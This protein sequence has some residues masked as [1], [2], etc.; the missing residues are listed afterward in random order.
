MGYK[1]SVY[2]RLSQH[3]DGAQTATARQEADCRALA[4]RLS[5]DVVAVYEDVDVSAYDRRKKRP[6]YEALLAAMARGEV[7]AVLVYDQ[8]RLVRHPAELERFIDAADRAGAR[9][10]AVTGS[11]DLST[12]VGRFI[13]RSL[14]NVA[15]MES[16]AKSR[17]LQRKHLELAQHGKVSGGGRRPFGYE[18][19]R[20]TLRPEEADLVRDAARR[21][22]AGDSVRSVVRDWRA[23]GVSTVTGA[24]WSTTTVKRLL[25][26][27][28]ISGQREHKGEL[29]AQATWPA[30]VTPE[31][32]DRLRALL[33]DPARS[34]ARGVEAYRYLLT[35]LV[36]C[37]RCEVKMSARP[38]AR[39]RR[40]YVCT[41]DRGGCDRCGIDAAGLEVLVTEAVL[42]AIDSPALADALD[43]RERNTTDAEL[44]RSIAA[45]EAAL[46]QLARDHYVDRVIGRIEFFAA[47]EPIE[48]RLEDVRARLARQART[49]AL[50]AVVGGG[51]A[52]RAS[53][54]QLSFD[55]RRAVV[56]AV[57]DR[58]TVAPTERANNRFD[59][60]RVDLV[61][62]Y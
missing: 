28:R 31:E 37:G 60:S 42:E 8:D 46:E 15:N 14:G 4:D 52:L 55:R 43:R 40:R 12:D 19:D 6:A 22:L 9:L 7:D 13:A 34:R 41:R 17:R 30:I 39:D 27:G 25:H 38:T 53:W 26:S 1:A 23:R 33:R 48:A 57:L 49:M 10:A 54:D 29:V 51:S 62:R 16:A 11:Y 5:W 61:W 32:T 56:A 3:R 24:P 21:V 59:A 47:K 45:D 36:V 35:G 58:V 20:V 2:T 50:R 44:R 18:A